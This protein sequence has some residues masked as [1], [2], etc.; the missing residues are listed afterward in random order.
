MKL[1]LT[2]K[3]RRKEIF[4]HHMSENG[5]NI[6]PKRLANTIEITFVGSGSS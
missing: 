3:E 1:L 5:G 2:K 6:I 4:Q